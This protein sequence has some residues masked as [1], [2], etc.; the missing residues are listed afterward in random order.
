M[1]RIF[2]NTEKKDLIRFSISIILMVETSGH[3][4]ERPTLLFPTS[5]ING[6][7]QCNISTKIVF[8]ISILCTLLSLWDERLELFETFV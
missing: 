5:V 2:I 8:L 7:C 6:P 4:L 3:G 1:E